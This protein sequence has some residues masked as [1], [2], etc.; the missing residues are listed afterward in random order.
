[1][2]KIRLAVRLTML[3]SHHAPRARKHI[4]TLLKRHSELEKQTMQYETALMDTES[5]VSRLSHP[6]HAKELVASSAS[7]SSGVLDSD[8][9]VRTLQENIR[10]ERMEILAVEQTTEDL[11]EKVSRY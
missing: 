5:L 1:M 10:R 3:P 8:E 6:E 4:K 7:K 9:E 2:G 11:L